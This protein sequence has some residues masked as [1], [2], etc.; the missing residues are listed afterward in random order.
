MKVSPVKHYSEPDF[1]TRSILDERP[2]LLRFVPKRWQ[3][4]PVVLTALTGLCALTLGTRAFA[5]VGK[6]TAANKVAPLFE[7]GTGVGDF[8]GMNPNPRVFLSEDEAR[9]VILGEA[10]RAGVNFKVDSLVLDNAAV[11]ITD[12]YEFLD[13]IER[14]ASGKTS[15]NKAL[16]SISVKMPTW[17]SQMFRLDGTDAKRNISFEYV[18]EEDFEAWEK[19]PDTR[20]CTVSV[21][22]MKKAANV[23]RGGFEHRVGAGTVGVFYDPMMGLNEVTKATGFKV[24]YK[25]KN[26]NAQ[27]RTAAEKIKQ[28]SREDLRKQVQDFIKWLKAEGV[29]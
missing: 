9:A 23:L 11:P 12:R 4:N 18:S 27:Y 15:D 13:S 19:R 10:K 24:D 21:Y 17:H 8:G 3:R 29:I 20:A 22:D 25:A 1:P 28:L 7:H 14:S 26:L 6:S 2:E 16:T 5:D